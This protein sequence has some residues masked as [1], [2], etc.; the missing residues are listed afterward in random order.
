MY[1]PVRRGKMRVLD[2]PAEEIEEAF[3]KAEAALA[4]ELKQKYPIVS[5]EDVKKEFPNQWV[6]VRYINFDQTL[7]R[8]VAH[9]PD[10]TKVEA[11]LKSLHVRYPELKGVHLRFIGQHPFGREVAVG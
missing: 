3:Q 10:Y 4:E 8:L 2:I 7:V 6:L 5:M 11:E 9:A 1:N